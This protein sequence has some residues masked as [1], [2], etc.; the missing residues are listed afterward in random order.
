MNKKTPTAG[1]VNEIVRAEPED[2][3]TAEEVALIL[4]V[5]PQTVRDA[6]WRGKIP[7]VRLWSGKKKV[8]LRFKR[9]EIEAFITKR[10]VPARTT[11]AAAR[12]VRRSAR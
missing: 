8:L 6:A 7:C 3:L 2:L 1:E 11:K 9:S 5:K 12:T 4:H 10:T